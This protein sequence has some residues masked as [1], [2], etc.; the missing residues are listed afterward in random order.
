LSI[1]IS[2]SKGIDELAWQLLCELIKC[3]YFNKCEGVEK[4]SSYL[5]II[6]ST[7]ALNIIK[8][9][10]DLLHQNKFLAAILK[11]YIS[12]FREEKIAKYIQKRIE[13]D[14]GYTNMYWLIFS[15]VI[16]MLNY[17]NI[18]YVLIKH[19]IIP[20]IKM[21]DVDIHICEVDEILRAC[22]EL[23]KL[24]AKFCTFRFFAH[25]FKLGMK[26]PSLDPTQEISVEIYPEIAAGRIIVAPSCSMIN[27]A[28]VISIKDNTSIEVKAQVLPDCENLYTII[29]HDWYSQRIP[30]AAVILFLTRIHYCDI[31]KLVQLGVSYGTI[32][33]I[34][35]F[36]KISLLVEQMLGLRILNEEFHELI[37]EL[38]FPGKA[39]INSWINDISLKQ[40]FPINIPYRFIL[41]SMPYHVIKMFKKI[42]IVKSLYDIYG[43]LAQPL[44]PYVYNIIKRMLHM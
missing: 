27:N 32:H 5:N 3:S 33:S 13:Q 9:S 19:Y 21:L 17:C 18:R 4:L 30:L 41:L 2:N 38:Q 16:N 23:N 20:H 11:P 34:Y 26:F 43:H 35:A 37:E 40:T 39:S 24:N 1:P 29:T 31:N 8:R 10:L 25:P 44:L 22:E 12:L 42:G 36:L 7:V 28:I 14:A 6:D 15:K